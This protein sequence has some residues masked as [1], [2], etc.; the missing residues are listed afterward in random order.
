LIAGAGAGRGG[1]GG[2]RE[3]AEAQGTG[4][5]GGGSQGEGGEEGDV[6]RVQKK[7]FDARALVEQVFLLTTKILEKKQKLNGKRNSLMPALLW[8]R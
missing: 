5:A 2:Q 6:E 3:D 7:L 8:S 4:A 1:G